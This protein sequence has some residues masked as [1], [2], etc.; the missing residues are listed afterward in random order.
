MLARL[1][2]HLGLW[3]LPQAHVVVGGNQLVEIKEDEVSIILL[4]VSQGLLSAARYHP[5]MLAT[6]PSARPS[7]NKAVYFFRASR[8]LSAFGKDSV[9]L[10]MTFT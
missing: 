4:A 2:F 8:N 7:A 9:P 3:V 5:L 6:Q 10:L 1:G